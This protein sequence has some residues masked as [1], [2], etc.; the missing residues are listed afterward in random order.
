MC[1]REHWR[2]IWARRGA[3]AEPI[4]CACT[5]P[6]AFPAP[7][8]LDSS[9]KETAKL[10]SRFS[11]RRC[12]AGVHGGRFCMQA[13]SA[14]AGR[15]WC[16]HLS[17]ERETSRH[18]LPAALRCPRLPFSR[19]QSLPALSHQLLLVSELPQA[20]LIVRMLGPLFRHHVD[21]LLAGHRARHGGRLGLGGRGSDRCCLTGQPA[22]G[23]M[24]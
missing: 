5:L 22:A 10:R 9:P 2:N 6:A 20:R 4:G 15:S 13:A 21:G 16:L 7:R 3:R 8:S 24:N 18:A 17:F 14:R 12:R 23:E 19:P 11:S 1:T